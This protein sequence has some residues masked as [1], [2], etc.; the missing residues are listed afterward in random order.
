MKKLL[1]PTLLLAFGTTYAQQI[2]RCSSF[3]YMQD[4]IAADPT[5]QG[6]I[7]AVN[8]DCD[9]YQLA[10]PNG[11]TSRAV[12]TIPVVVH[13]IYQNATE[14]IS[15]TRIFEQIQVLNE[16]FRKLNADVGN[17]NSAWDPIA[18]DC[19]IQFCLAARDPNG[20]WTNG[21]NRVSTTVSTFSTNNNVKYTSSGGANAWDRSKYLNLWVCDLGSSLL[22]YAQFPGQ[23]AATDGVVLHYRYTGKTGAIAPYNKG[24]TAVHEIGHWLALYHIWGDDGSA[25]TGSDFCSDTPNQADENY[26]CPAI[27]TVVTDAC[28]TTSPGVMWTNYMDYSD[29]ACMLFFTANQKTRMW[30]VLNG[31]RSSLQTSNGC[32]LNSV[33]ELSLS[34]AFSL[35]PSPTNGLVTLDFGFALPSDYDIAVYNTLG[36]KVREIHIDML[37]EQTLMLDLRDQ[38]AGLYFIEVRNKTE[39][40]TRKI[41][42][43]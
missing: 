32:I 16:D 22:G 35:Y 14:N 43:E 4:Q 28:T 1:L 36:E 11:Y 19:E 10:Y 34:H 23:A 25:C 17:I 30:A 31:S 18:A 5:V 29:D 26:T 37:N 39:K 7:D 40:I 41:L 38:A 21:I 8:A 27:G 15:D 42:V 9:A 20:N 24:R 33:D 2:Q 6:K 13:V 12:V 3:E